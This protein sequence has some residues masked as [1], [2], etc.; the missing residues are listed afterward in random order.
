MISAVKK[1]LGPIKRLFSRPSFNAMS[2]V[3]YVL[4]TVACF[5]LLGVIQRAFE[6]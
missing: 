5:G 6:R 2:I 4:L 3:V 1:A